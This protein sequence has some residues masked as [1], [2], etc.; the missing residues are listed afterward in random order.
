ME[1]Q[2]NALTLHFV[3]TLKGHIAVELK[4]SSLSLHFMTAF[5]C[6]N[7]FANDVTVKNSFQAFGL[8]S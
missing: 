4:R 7:L 3:K 1:R 8:K 2:R 5:L 6:S